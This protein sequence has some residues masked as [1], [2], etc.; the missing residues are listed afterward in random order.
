MK[1][2]VGK[3]QDQSEFVFITSNDRDQMETCN[4]DF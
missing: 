3:G 1:G 4:V 2:G